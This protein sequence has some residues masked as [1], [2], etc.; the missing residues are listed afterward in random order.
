[1]PAGDSQ[2]DIADTTVFGAYTGGSMEEAAYD[3]F[4]VARGPPP[5]TRTR[6]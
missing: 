4:G 3:L 6:T 1:M 2:K 5:S